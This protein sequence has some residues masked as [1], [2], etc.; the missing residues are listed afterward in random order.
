MASLSRTESLFGRHLRGVD[1]E[2]L[3]G[4]PTKLL[5]VLVA[6]E[7]SVGLHLKALAR[8]SRLLKDDDFRHQLLSAAGRHE[9]YETIQYQDEKY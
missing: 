4:N 2:S 9:I 3:D 8:V 6:P 1:F 7:E 5:F